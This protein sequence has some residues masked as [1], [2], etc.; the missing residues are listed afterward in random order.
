[1]KSKSDLLKVIKNVNNNLNLSYNTSLA[2]LRK[3]LFDHGTILSKN[4]QS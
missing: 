4:S 2:M 1:M 3:A